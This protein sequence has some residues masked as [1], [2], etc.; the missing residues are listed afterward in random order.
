MLDCDWIFLGGS[1]TSKNLPISVA[2]GCE[3]APSVI[4][5]VFPS[6]HQKKCDGDQ[7]WAEQV[8]L[9]LCAPGQK[10]AA[11]AK[12]GRPDRCGV[13]GNTARVTSLSER[14]DESSTQKHVVPELWLRVFLSGGCPRLHTTLSQ[15]SLMKPAAEIR[16]GLDLGLLKRVKSLDSC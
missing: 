6:G 5:R 2:A 1:A 3:V 12:N 10:I 13:A 4:S 7:K 14:R 9:K 16:T 15:S 11:P 8:R